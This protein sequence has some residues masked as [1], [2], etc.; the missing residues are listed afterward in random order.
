MR[1]AEVFNEAVKIDA[2][3]L[4]KYD[5]TARGGIAALIGKELNLPVAFV[6]TGEKYDDLSIFNADSYV[7]AFIGE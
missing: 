3:V 6:G 2:V 4:A 7:E 1:Q 5:S